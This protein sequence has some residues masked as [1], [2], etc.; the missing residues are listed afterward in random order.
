M[1]R[2]LLVFCLISLLFSCK[3]TQLESQ[4]PQMQIKE[5]ETVKSE[6]KKKQVNV[7]ASP[8]NEEDWA[9]FEARVKTSTKTS[10]NNTVEEPLAVLEVEEQIQEGNQKEIEKEVEA[11]IEKPQ[12]KAEQL[13]NI[14]TDA[15]TAVTELAEIT[16]IKEIEKPDVFNEEGE[17]ALYLINREDKTLPSSLFEA[18][19]DIK[20][21]REDGLIEDESTAVEKE[22]PVKAEE[23][24]RLRDTNTTVIAEPIIKS[25]LIKNILIY[26]LSAL[27]AL[28]LIGIFIKNVLLEKKKLEDLT[29][30][31]KIETKGIELPS[32]EITLRPGQGNND[33]YDITV[34][35][36]KEDIAEK[37]KKWFSK[38][39][40]E[41]KTDT[42]EDIKFKTEYAKVV[43]KDVEDGF[44]EI[45]K[46]GL[47]N[48]LTAEER[49]LILEKIVSS[50]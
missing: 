29:S 33:D 22:S 1:K 36:E 30:L 42:E 31:D 8:F 40:Q 16:E 3:S 21:T 9:E 15:K 34:E 12:K 46:L 35:E 47:G 38:K 7:S 23:I 32:T 4:E 25:S 24:I 13:V 19:K 37:S 14:Y 5:V 28:A 50:K 49:N 45:D 20:I 17:S 43:K 27:A 44:K 26:G 2:Y 41:E 18:E 10:K 6:N 11:V 48:N 39:S